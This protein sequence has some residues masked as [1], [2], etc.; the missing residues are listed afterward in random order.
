MLLDVAK[1]RSLPSGPGGGVT[2]TGE[3]NRN[4]AGTLKKSCMYTNEW[5]R[6]ADKRGFSPLVRLSGG[7]RS[8]VCGLR[9]SDIPYPEV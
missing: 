2:S 1:K 7:R 4:S 3:G 5:G 6:G 8:H 9:D